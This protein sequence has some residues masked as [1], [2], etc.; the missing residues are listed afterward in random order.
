MQYRMLCML[1]ILLSESAT[2]IQYWLG[3]TVDIGCV[4]FLTL[5]FVSEESKPQRIC[6][7]RPTMS[8]FTFDSLI[9]IMITLKDILAVCGL[10]YEQRFT[11]A[12][13]FPCECMMADAECSMFAT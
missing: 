12:A 2:N 7:P 1:Q 6:M 11:F 9:K 5:L 10:V 4:G 3:Y 8:C 13:V